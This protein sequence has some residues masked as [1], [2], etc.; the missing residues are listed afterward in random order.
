[1]PDH[2]I[3]LLSVWS[4]LL[5]VYPASNYV[6]DSVLKCLISYLNKLLLMHAC[7]FSSELLSILFRQ[8]LRHT[9]PS[10]QCYKGEIGQKSDL[11]MTW[12][13]VLLTRDQRVWTAFCKIFSELP[14]LTIFGML[15]YAPKYVFWGHVFECAKYGRAGYHELAGFLQSW[16]LSKLFPL[17]AY[18]LLFDN[19][20][21]WSKPGFLR[22]NI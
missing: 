11:V 14:Y 10:T 6:A 3:W 2:Q 17:K 15:K 18:A 5:Y 4:D 19:R 22:G 8:F 20:N 13:G 1:M 16:L 7:I 21:T 12:M 9:P